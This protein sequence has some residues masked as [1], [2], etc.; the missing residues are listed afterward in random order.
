[1][2]VPV[3]KP[4]LLQI[5]PWWC[6][7]SRALALPLSLSPSLPLSLSLSLSLSLFRYVGVIS[8]AAPVNSV[9]LGEDGF[10][11]VIQA[12]DEDRNHNA[13]LVFRIIEETARMFFS[14]DS[15]TG[16]IRYAAGHRVTRWSFHPFIHASI[17]TP[18]LTPNSFE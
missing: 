13:L 11:L 5:D 15:G 10:P 1:M 14:V 9:V 6:L 8:E 16:S 12:S 3:N 2:N 7:Q 4:D 17:V 18:S